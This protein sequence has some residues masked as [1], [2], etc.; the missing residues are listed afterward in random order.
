MRKLA[1]IHNNRYVRVGKD[2]S[3]AR[4][5]EAD[6]ALFD[7]LSGMPQFGRDASV[8]LKRTVSRRTVT[9]NGIIRGKAIASAV[10]AAMKGG[11]LPFVLNGSHADLYHAIAP[12]VKEHGDSLGLLVI[13][14]HLDDS[15]AGRNVG[16]GTV[17][18]HVMEGHGMP[19]RNVIVAQASGG[20][21]EGMASVHTYVGDKETR[22]VPARASRDIYM[23]ELHGWVSGMLREWKKLGVRKAWVSFDIDFLGE[24][25]AQAHHWNVGYRP[26]PAK[27]ASAQHVYGILRL[28]KEQG[29]ELAG[30]SIEEYDPLRDAKARG[31]TPSKAAIKGVA[32]LVHK[33]WG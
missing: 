25:Y 18:T 31:T 19:S 27:E 11:Q 9:K 10:S 23:D 1:L 17:I 7:E 13:D 30:I 5:G 32:G 12:A 4:R 15:E 14:R 3:P 16:P 2:I 24:R 33:L 28:M 29:I 20:E 22:V 6:K 8:Y 26:Q 21:R